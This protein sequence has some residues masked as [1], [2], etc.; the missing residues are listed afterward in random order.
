MRILNSQYGSIITLL[1]LVFMYGCNSVTEPPVHCYIPEPPIKKK[2]YSPKNAL[3]INKITDLRPKNETLTPNMNTD[4]LVLIPLWIYATSRVNPL[5]RYNFLQNDV[6]EILQRTV[7]IDLRASGLFRRIISK[8]I[9]NSQLTAPPESY[10]L[11]LTLIKAV[12]VRHL[13]TY[14]LSY[15]GAFLWLLGLPAS[16]G[17]VELEL[18]ASLH[19]PLTGKVI[20]EKT[21]SE[22]VSCTEWIY[23]QVDY[24]PPR[25]EYILKEIIPRITKNI[26]LF[27]LTNVDKP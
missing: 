27:V 22:S 19:E 7:A 14:G 3:F 26:R 9:V 16:Y 21:F 12:W 17:S 1:A 24:N 20:G 4:P 25:S 6:P 15:A 13:T 23:G 5:V 11:D 8:D 10:S 2:D 18:K